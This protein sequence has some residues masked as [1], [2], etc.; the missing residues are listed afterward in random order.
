MDHTGKEAEAMGVPVSCPLGRPGTG[1]GAGT[2]RLFPAYSAGLWRG[3]RN[4]SDLCPARWGPAVPGLP[5]GVVPIAWVPAADALRLWDRGWRGPRGGVKNADF[6]PSS[7]IPGPLPHVPVPGGGEGWTLWR[8]GSL[9][10]PGV[11]GRE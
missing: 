6:A 11:D 7:P 4:L 9:F 8:P 5:S 1:S 3:E 2:E 10:K